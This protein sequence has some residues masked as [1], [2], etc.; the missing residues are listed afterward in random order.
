MGRKRVSGECRLCGFIGPLSFEHIPP[1]A[2]FNGLRGKAFTFDQL[3]LNKRG[4]QIFQHGFGDYSLCER[5][6]NNTGSWYGKSYIDFA[7]QCVATKKSIEEEH[8]PIDKVLFSIYPLRILK[9]IITMFFTVNHVVFKD[10]YPLLKDFILSK[11]SQCFP[12]GLRIYSYLVEDMISTRISPGIVGMISMTTGET[13]LF[14]EFAYPP[15]GYIL[16]YDNGNFDNRLLD[17]TFFKNYGY[18]EQVNLNLS[19]NSL[20]IANTIFGEF[21]TP[22]EIMEANAANSV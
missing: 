13:N 3:F 22:Q 11:E 5:C 21:R 14:S 10:M 2:A 18:D 6:N 8:L 7:Y 15:L 9:Q 19:L 1:E 4:Y 17:I 20:P 16:S 12:D